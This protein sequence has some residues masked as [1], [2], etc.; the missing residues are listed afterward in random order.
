M[1]YFSIQDLPQGLLVP[2]KEHLQQH[3]H[4]L[5]HDVSPSHGGQDP[6][7]KLCQSW[8]LFEVSKT[9]VQYHITVLSEMKLIFSY[10]NMIWNVT[11]SVTVGEVEVKELCYRFTN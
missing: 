6:G 11:G 7:S 3:E 9:F 10:D 8:R 4:L 5:L 1:Y 2:D